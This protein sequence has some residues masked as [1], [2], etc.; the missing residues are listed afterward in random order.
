MHQT[1]SD[2]ISAT[3]DGGVVAMSDLSEER[4]VFKKLREELE[5]SYRGKWALVHKSDLIGTFDTFEEAASS[6]VA[7]FGRGPYLIRQI[8]APD[9]NLPVSLAFMT[10]QDA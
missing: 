10:M 5:A 3:K 7:K 9:E 2:T 6:A 8:G 1:L 4:K